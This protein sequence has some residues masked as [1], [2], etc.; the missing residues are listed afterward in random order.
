[1][2]IFEPELQISE[3]QVEEKELKISELK[4]FREIGAKALN[5]QKNNSTMLNQIDDQISGIEEGFLNRKDL[6]D[7]KKILDIKDYRIS[8]SRGNRIK[9]IRDS[10]LSRNRRESPSYFDNTL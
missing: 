7:D 2:N 10:Q 6:N 9:A 5:R 8:S 3:E 1:M 4:K